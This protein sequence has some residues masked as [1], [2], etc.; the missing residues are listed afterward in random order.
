MWDN[1]R[2]DPINESPSSALLLNCLRTRLLI[3]SLASIFVHVVPTSRRVYMKQ[4]FDLKYSSM[5]FA[6]D[7]AHTPG[8]DS[9]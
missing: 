6:F 4:H 2:V 5:V 7:I 9:P 8:I 1:V 3:I